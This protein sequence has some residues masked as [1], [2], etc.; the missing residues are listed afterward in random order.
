MHAELSPFQSCILCSSIPSSGM[1]ATKK[2]TEDNEL[3][4]SVVKEQPYH[5]RKLNTISLLKTSTYDFERD[6]LLFFSPF[7]T[8]STVRGANNFFSSLRKVSNNIL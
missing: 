5:I 7:S 1:Q 3:A 8:C 2:A 6:S 4:A